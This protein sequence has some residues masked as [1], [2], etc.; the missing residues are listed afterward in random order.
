VKRAPRAKRGP[1]RREGAPAGRKILA[2]LAEI[3]EALESGDDSRLT[4]RTVDVGEPGAYGAAAVKATR[5][6]IGASQRV[7]ARMLGVSTVLVQSWEQGARR[8][9]ALARRLF[10]EM[11]A[12]PHH[13]AALARP[14]PGG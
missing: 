7:F 11:N 3:A 12:R 8:P 9:S 4:A 2:G 14:R 6:R 5:D 1:A 10:D 13:W